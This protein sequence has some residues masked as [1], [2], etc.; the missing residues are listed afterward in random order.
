MRCFEQVECA[1]MFGPNSCSGAL[2]GRRIFTIATVNEHLHLWS[3]PN[4]VIRPKA[5]RE[6]AGGSVRFNKRFDTFSRYFLLIQTLT[7]IRAL[8]QIP[9]RA[10]WR[11]GKNSGK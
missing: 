6:N 7:P 5:K 8:A 11:P 9:P 10:S 2:N 3:L 4:Q 1:R